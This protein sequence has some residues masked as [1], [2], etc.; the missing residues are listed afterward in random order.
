MYIIYE[1]NY[2]YKYE[3]EYEHVYIYI[4]T[5]VYSLSKTIANQLG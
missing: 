4:S 2:E 1:C 5:M 3:Y